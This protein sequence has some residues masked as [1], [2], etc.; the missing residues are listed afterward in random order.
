MYC[1][2]DVDCF[3]AEH[4]KCKLLS[5][6]PIKIRITVYNLWV[7]VDTA[8]KRGHETKVMSYTSKAHVPRLL[9]KCIWIGDNLTKRLEID[10]CP[11]NAARAK[12]RLPRT[13]RRRIIPPNYSFN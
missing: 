3:M 1:G 11:E 9:I 7:P 12:K 10:V 2:V 5:A 4:V 6:N 13:S 8:S